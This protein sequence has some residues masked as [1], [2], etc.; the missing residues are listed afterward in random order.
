MTGE[1]YVFPRRKEVFGYGVARGLRA[2]HAT[3]DTDAAMEAW[4]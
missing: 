3:G 1:N 2:P 4:S